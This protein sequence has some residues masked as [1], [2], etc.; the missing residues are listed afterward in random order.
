MCVLWLLFIATIAFFFVGMPRYVDDFWYAENIRPWIEGRGAGS[1][2]PAIVETWRFHYLTDNA[3]LANVLIVPLLL[4]PK[5]MGSLPA[6]IALGAAAVWLAAM[7]ARRLGFFSSALVMFLMAY[8]LPWYDVM[9]SED[10]QINYHIPTLLAVWCMAIFLGKAR[11]YGIAGAFAVGLVTG[12]WH[13]GFAVPLLAGMAVAAISYRDYRRPECLA[14]AAGLAAGLIY[15]LA[16]P[17][18]FN[19]AAEAAEIFTLSRIA[20]VAASHPAFLLACLLSAAMLLSPRRR[21]RLAEPLYIILMVSAVVSIG[22]QLV[23]TRTP[24]T[25]WWGEFASIFMVVYLLRGVADSRSITV[26]AAAAAMALLAFA[27]QAL[28][29]YYTVV[30]R[31]DFDKAI[32]NYSL[33]EPAQHF[34]DFV[35]EHEAPLLAWFSPDFNLFTSRANREIIKDYY[36]PDDGHEFA[37]IPEELRMATPATGTPLGGN[38]GARSIGGHIF[39]PD[40]GVEGADEFEATINFGRFT[41]RGMRVFYIPFTSEA[42][43]RRYLYLYPW[44]AI[45]EYRLGRP[46]AIYS[47]DFTPDT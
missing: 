40:P 10:L 41:R 17:A 2:W 44:R 5:W 13:E 47:S 25:G 1:P 34:A 7:A 26:K 23:A 38:I 22:I 8:C 9:G 43:G 32:A 46:Q 30:I 11:P 37:V 3:R 12:A 24:R 33:P 45:I 14:V 16:C 6:A 18:F 19:R 20:V 15:L 27:H 29:D 31:R 4:L 39:M 21:R 28:T 35:T 42:D 36:H